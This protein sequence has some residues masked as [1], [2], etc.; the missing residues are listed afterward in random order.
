MHTC[1]PM[2]LGYH[3]SRSI[4][5]NKTAAINELLPAFKLSIAIKVDVC[6][7]LFCHAPDTQKKGKKSKVNLIW[8]FCCVRNS[9]E[10]IC[11][12]CQFHCYRTLIGI[13]WNFF[14]IDF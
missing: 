4:I 11:Q 14:K 6:Q 1:R 13:D 7:S 10:Y 2:V 3:L 8:I 12:L 9:F 5:P